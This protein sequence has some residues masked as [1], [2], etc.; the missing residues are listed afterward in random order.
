MDNL[1]DSFFFSFSRKHIHRI[2]SIAI[3]IFH[4][5]ATL[6]FKN[7]IHRFKLVSTH[8]FIRDRSSIEIG[9]KIFN[10]FTSFTES[11]ERARNAIIFILAVVGARDTS[12]TR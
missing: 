2:F 3:F 4:F 12:M 8:V 7:Y 10:Y 9:Q 6:N 1:N 11:F 5:C